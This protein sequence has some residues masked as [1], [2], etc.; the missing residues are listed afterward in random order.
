MR[1]DN[2]EHRLL[3]SWIDA[4]RSRLKRFAV[5]EVEKKASHLEKHV[6]IVEILV[7]RD[8]AW[9]V[10]LEFVYGSCRLGLERGKYM[11]L[12]LHAG[13]GRSVLKDPP[14]LQRLPPF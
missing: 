1:G 7:S 14:Y 11:R 13:C 8:V 12:E 6:N 3:D 2:P 5:V 4:L 10:I 9:V